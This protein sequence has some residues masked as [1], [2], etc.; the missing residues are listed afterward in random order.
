M[1]RLLKAPQEAER[2]HP[3]DAASYVDTADCGEKSGVTPR[4]L[5]TAPPRWLSIPERVRLPRRSTPGFAPPTRGTRQKPADIPQRPSTNAANP[6]DNEFA[7]HDAS[8]QPRRHGLSPPCVARPSG[9]Q[10]SMSSSP[11][12]QQTVAVTSPWPGRPTANPGTFPENPYNQPVRSASA[13][14]SVADDPTLT[15]GT[16]DRFRDSVRHRDAPLRI[17]PIN[18]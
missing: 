9:T 15:S 16:S 18:H 4:Y 3:V 12:F 10:S 7:A 11:P 6:M 14:S 17:N 1:N 5:L 13:G 2:V 8:L